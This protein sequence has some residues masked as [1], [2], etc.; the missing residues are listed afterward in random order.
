MLTLAKARITNNNPDCLITVTIDTTQNRLM[1]DTKRKKEIKTF[2]FIKIK[3]K[4]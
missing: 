3:R 4:T 2:V 1:I